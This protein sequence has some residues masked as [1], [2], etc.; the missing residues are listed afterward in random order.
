MMEVRQETDYAPHHVQKVLAFF[1]AMRSFADWIQKGG[2]EIIYLHLD[3]PKNTQSLTGN[4]DWIIKESGASKFEY[5]LP[6]EHRL[7]V[8]LAKYTKGLSISS[9][10]ADSEHFLTQ[11]EDLKKYFTGKKT[12]LMESFYRHMRRK[13]DI[14]MDGPNPSTGKWNYDADNRS[15]LQD[16]SLLAKHPDQSKLVNDLQ[17]ML[18]KADVSTIGNASGTEINWPCTR[19]DGLVLLDFFCEELLPNFG[20]YQDAMHTDDPFLFHSKLSFALNIKL[21]HPLEVIHAVENKWKQ[22]PEK[23][24]IAQVE[25][26]IR[27]ILGWREYMR[28]VYWAEMPAYADLNFFEHKAPLPKFYWSGDT[29]MNCVSKCITQS[30][31]FGYAHH[32]QRL[33][34][35]GNFALLAGIDPDEVDN[36][37][38]G[39]YIDAIQWVQITNTRGMSQYADGGIVGTKPY[40]SSANYIDKMSNYCSGC[41]YNKNKKFG[42]KAC[43]FNSLYWSFYAKHRAKLEKNPRIGFVYRTLDRMNDREK[44]L[45]QADEYLSNLEKL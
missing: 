6:D 33:M 40:I 22:N 25:G 20:K 15:K 26:F 38:L 14:L 5:Q 29:R 10:F 44:I 11:R 12:Y 13:Y 21:L 28:G 1:T 19:T 9:E 43:P 16:I 24:G 32:I 36:W 35:T 30:L 42:E 7:D 41:H 8:Q 39:I 45:A 3:N 27:Q 37:Y 34:V 31:E 2:H 17:E 4:L 23:Y 18:A